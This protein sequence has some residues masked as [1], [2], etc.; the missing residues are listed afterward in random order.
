MGIPTWLPCSAMPLTSPTTCL[1]RSSKKS[2]DALPALRVG[3]RRPGCTTVAT[4]RP[5]S[6]L[7]GIASLRP[8]QRPSPC[9][10]QITSVTAGRRQIPRSSCGGWTALVSRPPTCSAA[11]TATRA[12]HLG[13]SADTRLFRAVITAVDGRSPG[14]RSLLVVCGAGVGLPGGEHASNGVA[15]GGPLVLRTMGAAGAGSG[16]FRCTGRRA[17]LRVQV[18]EPPADPG[19]GEPV[20]FRWPFPRPAEICGEGTGEAASPDP[21]GAGPGARS[22]CPPRGARCG[23][24]RSRHRGRRGRPVDPA[25]PVLSLLA[26]AGRSPGTSSRSGRAPRLSARC[27]YDGYRITRPRT[28]LLTSTSNY[29]LPSNIQG[30]P[31]SDRL[32]ARPFS[33]VVKRILPWRRGASRFPVRRSRASRVHR[34]WRKAPRWQVRAE[35]GDAHTGRFCCSMYCLTTE[36]GAPPTVPAK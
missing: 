18:P 34:P 2:P 6:A 12:W 21:T 13:T 5:F 8:T 20:R 17:R 14:L 32:P 3:S 30:T 4:A 10:V 15:G 35:P 11:C 33:P 16:G 22:A 28:G 1:C 29:Q 19:R 36:S 27:C 25:A 24:R 23:V 31:F 7:P 26:P 9:S